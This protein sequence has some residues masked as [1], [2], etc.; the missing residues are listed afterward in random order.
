MVDV[1]G[2]HSEREWK[3]EDEDE[4]GYVNAEMAGKEGHRRKV[5]WL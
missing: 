4:D 3:D 2:K 1:G 5:S